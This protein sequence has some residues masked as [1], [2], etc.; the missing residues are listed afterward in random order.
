MPGMNVTQLLSLTLWRDN[1]MSRI[2]LLYIMQ[3]IYS[4]APG[5]EQRD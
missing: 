4:W 1:L 3:A 2:N 5:R